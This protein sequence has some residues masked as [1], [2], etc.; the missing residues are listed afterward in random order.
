MIYFDKSDKLS[1]FAED[2]EILIAEKG[3]DLLWMSL[4]AHANQMFHTLS[5]IVDELF[6]IPCTR[7]D[8]TDNCI[9]RK[10]V[11]KCGRKAYKL[12]RKIELITQSD[13][14]SEVAN[15][16]HLYHDLILNGPRTCQWMAKVVFAE[17]M[18]SILQDIEAD[19][20]NCP[21]SPDW[22]EAE[23]RADEYIDLIYEIFDL[24]SE[25]A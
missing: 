3:E 21:C 16:T 5:W 2:Y 22:C 15:L 12:I 13:T 19:L 11:N 9:A 4:V 20:I 23:H 10:R 6:E 1:E 8:F 18:F 14:A 24:I 25:T 7:E 17:D